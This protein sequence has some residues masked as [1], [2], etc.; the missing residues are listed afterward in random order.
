VL[1]LHKLSDY[2]S[3]PID[4]EKDERISGVYAWMALIGAVIAYDAIAI[5]TKKVETLTRYFWRSTEMPT[6]GVL[7]IACWSIVTAHL[8]AEKNI[9]RKK[10][11]EEKH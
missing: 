6:K 5:K 8:L 9:R 11:G 4:L 2:Y 1:P 3:V 7:P 10:F